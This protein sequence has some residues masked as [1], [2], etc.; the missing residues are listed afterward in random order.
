[1]KRTFAICLTILV[2][3][4]C[5]KTD[6]NPATGG[7]GPVSFV[8]GKYSG[9]ATRHLFPGSNC[10][11]PGEIA[12][13]RRDDVA[14]IVIAAESDTTVSII[15]SSVNGLFAPKSLSHVRV[16]QTGN[17]YQLSCPTGLG[18]HKTSSVNVSGSVVSG[19]I[20]LSILSSD[21][22]CIRRC[23]YS[24]LSALDIVEFTAQLKER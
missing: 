21:A 3:A 6:D 23:G 1:M 20:D 17:T 13:H 16:R 11:C 15:I 8:K 18:A 12:A 9:S 24:A 10:I 2:A 22:N 4:A 7:P 14:N 19:V 5:A